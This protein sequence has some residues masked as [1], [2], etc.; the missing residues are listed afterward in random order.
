MIYVGFP[1]EPEGIEARRTD[2]N[3]YFRQL[4][5]PEY[6]RKLSSFGRAELPLRHGAQ[7]R[8]RPDRSGSAAP[9][10]HSSFFISPMC[11]GNIIVND[12]LS[13]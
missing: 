12:D 11:P 9:E 10:R 3:R 2:F 13:V 7:I 4:D 1:A 8:P 6:N 5:N